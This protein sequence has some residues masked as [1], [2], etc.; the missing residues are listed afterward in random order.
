MEIRAN[1]K[2]ELEERRNGVEMEEIP[3]EFVD[4]K[5]RQ[6]FNPKVGNS[7]D[8]RGILELGLENEILV[9]TVKLVGRMYD[10]G[11]SL[12]WREGLNLTLKSYSKSHIDVEVEEENEGVS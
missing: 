1:E 3:V 12:G 9:A 11:L 10:G 8:N 4:G 6:R 2:L 5:K 7:R